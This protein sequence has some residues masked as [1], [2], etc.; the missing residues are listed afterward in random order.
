M[1][2]LIHHTAYE[3][4]PDHGPWSEQFRVMHFPEEWRTEFLDLYHRRWRR[5]QPPGLPIRRLNALLRAT[6]PGV[7]ATGR[8]AGSSSEVP[9]FYATD[10]QPAELVAPLL[11]S[12]VMTL[13]PGADKDPVRAAG[14]EV[15]LDRALALID[16]V[17][18]SW[19]H[20]SVDLAATELSAGG[21]AEPDRRLY[22]LLPEKIG[23]LLAARP[24]LMDGV[25]LRFRQ[26]TR[27]QGVEL[28]SWPP[29][30][31]T[32]HKRAWYYSALVTVTVQTVPF[33]DRFR[34]HVSY[35]VRRWATGS[36][37]KLQNG[38]GATVLL[39][40]PMPWSEASEPRRRLAVNS[41]LLDRTLRVPVWSRQSLV[42]LLPELDIQ[43]VYPKPAELTGE[44]TEW[45]AG[46]GGVAAGILY[47]TGFGKHGVGAGL[48]PLERMLLD[49]WV[50]EGIRPFLRRVPALERVHRRSNP[51][52]LAASYTKSPEKLAERA[53]LRVEA[54][55]AAIRAV[56]DG[57]PLSVDV[58]W[59]T[60][61][62]RDGLIAALR[63]WLDLPSTVPDADG[64]YEWHADGL[65]VVLHARTLESL[66]SALRVVREASLSR[67]HS[68]ATA[69]RERAVR[70]TDRLGAHRETVGIAFVEILGRDRFPATDTDPKSALRLGSAGAGRVSQ[71]IVVPE[72]ADGPLPERAD[73]AVADGMRQLG[74]MVP[75]E[76]KLDEALTDDMQYLAL[77][78]IRHQTGAAT[79]Q[80]GRH[81]VALRIRPRDP[82][83]PIQGWDEAK[84]S[85][86]PYARLLLTIATSGAAP[87]HREETNRARATETETRYEAERQIRSLLYQVRDR[88]T[89]LL[90][91]SGNLRKVWLGLNNGQLAKDR[92]V[93]HGERP[94]R[95]SLFGADLRVVLLRDANSREETA[96]WYAPGAQ[97]DDTPGVSIG[98]WAPRGADPDNRVFTS[99]VGK[100]P[101]GGKVRTDL[102]KIVPTARWPHAPAATAW[103]PQ[104]L[105]LT[106]LGC[107]SEQALELARRTD[108]PMDRPALLAAA[109]HQLRL[110]DEYHPLSRPLPLHLAKLAEEYLLPLA[111]EATPTSGAATSDDAEVGSPSVA[112]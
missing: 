5:N 26:V 24:L 91:N 22:H 12:W 110:H 96:E 38:S 32:R 56:L 100:P 17:T 35:G 94:A 76:Q 50:E 92:L 40:A 71:F 54:R 23:A 79:R 103:N 53:R 4:D 87:V 81:L 48:M 27:D 85:W 25:E 93:F 9:W 106:V 75:P 112:E 57:Q 29:R 44:A 8:G 108:R 20:E 63:R 104:A 80:A 43:H 46:R 89:L 45:L 77:W 39:D 61:E 30:A 72:D 60:E 16:E 41:I 1:Y 82:V 7:L 19:R 52:L 78:H 97:E 62:T 51:R 107:L 49:Q 86:V 47:D 95:L 84:K 111:G 14:H 73:S 98:L 10:D 67:A 109:V 37:V 42:D 2:S 64:T 69:V 99:T 101:T 59:Q 65:C 13:P 11:A 102:R 21:T 18:P 28:V 31:Y 34:V 6:A 70:M 3:P 74:A 88:P 33:T 36:P 66:G 15:A 83:H 58:V 55:R 68:V 90:A 105:E